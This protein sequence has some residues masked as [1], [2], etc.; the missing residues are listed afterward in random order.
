MRVSP[1]IGYFH[2]DYGK[3]SIKRFLDS[4][5]KVYPESQVVNCAISCKIEVAMAA[6]AQRYAEL[7]KE[8]RGNL[9]LCD[10]DIEAKKP[11]ED[12]GGQWEIGLTESQEKTPLMPFNGGMIFAKD[13]PGAQHFLDEVRWAAN[14][15]P[16]G[17]Q[18]LWYIDQ[19]AL[20]YVAKG[21]PVVKVFGAECNYIPRFNGDKPDV[22]FMHYKG[23]RKAWL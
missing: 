10:T 2:N 19:L 15:I 11:F 1:T 22:Y 3:G 7:R 8:V 23:N 6:R 17:F 18:Y 12:W 21:N 14:I 4:V 20:G 5:G 9:I 13:S 16:Q